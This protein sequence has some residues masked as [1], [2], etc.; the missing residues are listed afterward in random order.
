[1]S[2]IAVS[3][4]RRGTCRRGAAIAEQLQDQ[5]ELDLR[6]MAVGWRDDRGDVRLD[7]TVPLPGPEQ[8]RAL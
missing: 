1:M 3:A 4:S 2:H 8:C 6:G 5:G 7:H